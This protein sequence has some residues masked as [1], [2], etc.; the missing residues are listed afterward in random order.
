[1]LAELLRLLAEVG[2][3]VVWVFIFIAAVVAVFT[4]YVRIASWATLSASDPGLQKVR[5]QVF[6]DL[7]GLFRRGRDR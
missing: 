2:P 3:G 7:L 6:R 1:V 5:Y 4:L